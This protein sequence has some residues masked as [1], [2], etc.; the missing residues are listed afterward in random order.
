MNPELRLWEGLRKQTMAP[1]TDAPAALRETPCP[2][3]GETTEWEREDAGPL[4]SLRGL[5]AFCAC[6]HGTWWASGIEAVTFSDPAAIHGPRI[7]PAG[8]DLYEAENRWLQQ[9]PPRY[10]ATAWVGFLAMTCVC[11][12][13]VVLERVANTP[14]EL[15]DD[16]PT[17]HV[18][19]CTPCG[20][21]WRATVPPQE[22]PTYAAE[23]AAWEAARPDAP[24]WQAVPRVP[25][26]LSPYDRAEE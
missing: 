18:G 19:A 11:G 1:P 7:R 4:A 15:A 23:L 24:L 9:R 8:R 10:D 2:A 26:D 14:D 3:C 21:G 17:T 22:R 13:R 12:V 16:D 6:G 5:L 25:L 20:I